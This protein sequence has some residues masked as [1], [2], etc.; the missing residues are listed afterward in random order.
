MGDAATFWILQVLS[1][2]ATVL[3]VLCAPHW[4]TALLPPIVLPLL[5]AALLIFYRLAMSFRATAPQATWKEHHLNSKVEIDEMDLQG[6]DRS[7]A[8]WVVD[9]RALSMALASRPA[10]DVLADLFTRN[11]LLVPATTASKFALV[12]YRQQRSKDDDFTLDTD[13]LVS[14][15]SKATAAGVEFLWLDAWCYRT[16]GEYDHELFCSML[17]DVVGSAHLV[18]WLP[19]SRNTASSSYQFRLWCTF[20]ACA[21][22]QRGL[23]VIIAGVGPSKSQLLLCRLGVFLPWLPFAAPPPE[24]LEDLATYNSAYML[25]CVVCPLFMLVWKS[26][27]NP[28]AVREQMPSLARQLAWARNGQLVLRVML[29]AAG[30]AGSSKASDAEVAQLA[31]ALREELPWL[32][33]YDRRDVLV[34]RELLDTLRGT[35][36][37]AIDLSTDDGGGR[38]APGSCKRAAID[39]GAYDA[40]VLS[41]YTAALQRPSD[42]DRVDLPDGKR[43]P[44]GEWLEQKH[45]EAWARPAS[46]HRGG[47]HGIVG[48]RDPGSVEASGEASLR[49]ARKRSSKCYRLSAY[50]SSVQQ[51]PDEVFRVPL[52]HLYRLGWT[53]DRGASCQLTTPLG[54]MHV[55]PPKRSIWTLDKLSPCVSQEKYTRP[56]LVATVYSQAISAANMLV[57]WITLV[58]GALLPAA[59]EAS[60]NTTDA[61]S[62]RVSAWKPRMLGPMRDASRFTL[63]ILPAG[64]IALFLA[65]YVGP[66]LAYA[67]QCSAAPHFPDLY[68]QKFGD[69]YH[70][71]DM[72]HGTLANAIVAGILVIPTFC[73]IE[74]RWPVLDASPGSSRALEGSPTAIWC[75]VLMLAMGLFQT[76]TASAR[77]YHMAARGARDGPAHVLYPPH[78]R[79]DG[80]AVMGTWSAS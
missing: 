29:Q 63:P 52:A 66:A 68:R 79:T 21:V 20:E 59:P 73:L 50:R 14:V 56:Q 16:Q 34:V 22:A 43:L 40:L 75:W 2:L 39:A 11:S 42:G 5:C 27:G 49:R 64:P 60:T 18:I 9:V 45:L 12:S 54:P 53:F 19:R 24:G 31:E 47:G 55:P 65:C 44:V 3:P 32:P 6:G 48:R 26:A 76:Q 30:I 61:I 37:P 58:Q 69:G 7:S 62:E 78:E 70:I 17:A 10:A 74:G 15:V 1:L 38:R 35:A 8:L 23:P 36:Q 67:S 80:V 33:C 13:A 25:V 71:M 57:I 28:A 46:P 72:V 4:L 41:A 51:D 77:A